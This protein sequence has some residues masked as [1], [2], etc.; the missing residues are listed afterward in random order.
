MGSGSRHPQKRLVSFSYTYIAHSTSPLPSLFRR[1]KHYDQARSQIQIHI[2]NPTYEKELTI[3]MMPEVGSINSSNC[4]RSGTTAVTWLWTNIP[5]FA[6]IGLC[7]VRSIACVVMEC[8]DVM[9]STSVDC[10]PRFLNL[11]Q[12]LDDRRQ[13]QYQFVWSIMY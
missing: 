8:E 10:Q 1:P 4:F 3:N 9:F 2:R 11:A 12:L 6:Y 7:N 13:F 5:N